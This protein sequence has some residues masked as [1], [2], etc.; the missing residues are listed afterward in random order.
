[1]KALERWELTTG[2]EPKKRADRLLRTLTW[3]LQS[4]VTDAIEPDRLV[5]DEGLSLVNKHLDLRARL[6]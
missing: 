5:S 6:R 4:E 1:M 3:Q 2:Y